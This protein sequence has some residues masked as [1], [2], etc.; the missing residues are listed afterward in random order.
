MKE[1]RCNFY[2][3]AV[4]GSVENKLQFKLVINILIKYKQSQEN[5]F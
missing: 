2:M 5:I 3:C 4:H 1:V